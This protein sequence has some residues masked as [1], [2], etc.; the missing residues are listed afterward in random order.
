MQPI[1]ITG[2]SLLTLASATQALAIDTRYGQPERTRYE[3]ARVVRV[4]PVTG[5]VTNYRPTED[6]WQEEVVYEHRPRSKT[7]QILG[8]IIGGA[9]GYHLGHH[10]PNKKAGAAIGAILGSSIARDAD[11]NRYSERRLETRCETVDIA[12]DQEVVVGYDVTYVYQG[13]EYQTFMDE[14]PG[15]E[16]QVRVS[17][18]PVAGRSR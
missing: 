13:R 16:L 11:R 7:P 18:E 1:M 17:V 2:I 9:I 8:G 3:T 10:K 6:C 5:R 12:Y 14:D 15:R 4:E